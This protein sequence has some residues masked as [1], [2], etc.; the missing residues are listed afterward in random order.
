M[1]VETVDLTPEDASKLLAHSQGQRQR[2]IS[3][4]HVERIAHAIRTG[5]WRETHQ[6]IAL[7]RDGV[8]IDGQHRLSAIVQA[9][10]PVRLMIAR[11]VPAETFDVIDTGKIRGPADVLTLGGHVNTTKLAS[12]ARMVLT[13]D[14]VIGTTDTFRMVR[15]GFTSSDLL[16][17]ADSQRGQE[18]GRILH[19]AS[20]MAQHLGRSGFCTWLAVAI[21]AIRESPVDD[22]LGLEF[23]ER[24]RDGA[25]LP[26]GSPILALRRYLSSDQG[27][28]RI[29][30]GDRAQIGIATTIK[31]FN[32]W[33]EGSTRQLVTFRIGVERMPAVVPVVPGGPSYPRDL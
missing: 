14:Q 20:G 13:Y 25:S 30:G 4:G 11:D 33:L 28:I 2:S 17:F 24:L 10:I 7:D 15:Q 27:L 22:G 9:G 31:T 8:V 6:P 3:K 12:S 26:A 16:R 29:N 1:I 23:V 32:A 5:Q 18:L 19:P 21:L